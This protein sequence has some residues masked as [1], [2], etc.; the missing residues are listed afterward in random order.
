MNDY[1]VGLQWWMQPGAQTANGYLAAI[2]KLLE[3]AR[4]EAAAGHELR[5]HALN[6][7]AAYLQREA[8]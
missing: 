1:D 2:V 3:A 8:A 7:A 4:D 6:A 5:A